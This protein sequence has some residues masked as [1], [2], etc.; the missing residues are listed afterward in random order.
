MNAAPT[1]VQYASMRDIAPD[2]QRLWRGSATQQKHRPCRARG[3]GNI[4]GTERQEPPTAQCPVQQGETRH[5]DRYRGKY[6]PGWPEVFSEQAGTAS[7]C[8]WREK[9][10]FHRRRPPVIT[11]PFRSTLGRWPASI[12]YSLEYLQF[13]GPVV[14]VLDEVDAE[15][16]GLL[17]PNR[18]E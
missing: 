8:V 2:G 7:Q 18:A 16:L 4:T 3:H 11:H 12:R 15:R 5:R 14:S 10:Q 1:T 17:A 9:K 13:G 6:L